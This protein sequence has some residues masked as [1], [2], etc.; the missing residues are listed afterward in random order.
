MTEIIIITIEL[1]LLTLSTL[2]II[3]TYNNYWFNN[4]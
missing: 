4:N 2:L 3:I 1:V